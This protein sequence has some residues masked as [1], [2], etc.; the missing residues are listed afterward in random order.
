M[1]T[2]TEAANVTRTGQLPPSQTGLGPGTPENK[3]TVRDI[4]HLGRL[5]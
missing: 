4:R 1:E 3:T 2:R 5:F